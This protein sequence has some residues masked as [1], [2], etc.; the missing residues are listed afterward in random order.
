[1]GRGMYIRR[2]I[3]FVQHEERLQGEMLV[4]SSDPHMLQERSDDW[5]VIEQQQL[6]C[7]NS[8]Y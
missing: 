1:M 7:P 3:N 6:L 2:R 8:H 4:L 5:M